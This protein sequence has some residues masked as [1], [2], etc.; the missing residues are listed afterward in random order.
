MGYTTTPT[1]VPVTLKHFKLLAHLGR[2]PVSSTLHLYCSWTKFYRQNWCLYHEIEFGAEFFFSEEDYL[3]KQVPP[4][5][6]K[7]SSKSR[8]KANDIKKETSPPTLPRSTSHT[9]LSGPSQAS[10]YPRTSR[11]RPRRSAA[12]T[13]TSYVIPDSDDEAIIEDNSENAMMAL[14]SMQAKKR[15]VES[16]LQ[17]WIKHLSALLVDEQ[18]KVYINA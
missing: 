13:V 4:S 7:R 15:K 12:S 16:N 17:R 18:R 9:G 8:I 2:A 11:R 10:T 5:D 3:S 1:H 14:L 6:V